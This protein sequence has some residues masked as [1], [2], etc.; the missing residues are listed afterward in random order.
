MKRTGIL[1]KA[2]IIILFVN[3][4]TS[5]PS[6]S[7]YDPFRIQPV[8][9]KVVFCPSHSHFVLFMNGIRR[10][11]YET[12]TRKCSDIESYKSITFSEIP[13]GTNS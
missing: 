13:F 11:M 4:L 6:C 5:A 10:Q 1:F 12:N 2:V 8:D 7:I 3:Y 9:N